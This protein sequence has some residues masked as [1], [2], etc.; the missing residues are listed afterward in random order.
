LTFGDLQE[1][2]CNEEWTEGE[3]NCLTLIGSNLLTT[4]S[5]G[6]RKKEYWGIQENDCITVKNHGGYWNHT[7][8]VIS[9]DDKR[10]LVTVKWDT[11]QKKS[12][13]Q[14]SD[15]VVTN[16]EADPKPRE[17]KLPDYYGKSDAFSHQIKKQ[18]TGN[19]NGMSE[20]L[21]TPYAD[22]KYS[23]LNALKKCAKGSIAN[24]LILLRF[25][26]K[27]VDNFWN[28]CFLPIDKIKL[29]LGLE[30]V[31]N[32]V[33]QKC[34]SIITMEKSIWILWNKFGFATTSHFK[35]NRFNQVNKTHKIISQ[36][37]FPVLISV[38]STDTQYNHVVVVFKDMMIDYEKKK[39]I[40]FTTNN[41]SQIC[42][43]FTKFV[44]DLRDHKCN[45]PN[46]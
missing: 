46:K 30:S 22:L 20:L 28:M 11:T 14:F 3:M 43:Q 23:S 15:I 32:I 18:R 36:M 26:K 5:Y 21:S 16:V 41:L 10:K 33:M 27:D 4:V 38:K 25:D 12:I 44:R 31:S 8:K 17:S 1:L 37:K 42:G 35:E 29:K 2:L 39:P 34:G 6:A 9:I 45:R 7:T 24:L 19:I 40:K 13:V